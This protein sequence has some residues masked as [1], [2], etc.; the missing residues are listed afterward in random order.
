[1][2]DQKN[3]RV[4]IVIKSD[5][6]RALPGD[7]EPRTRTGPR[8]SLGLE[9]E[10]LPGHAGLE[11]QPSIPMHSGKFPMRPSYIYTRAERRV[12]PLYHWYP[13]WDEQFSVP[14]S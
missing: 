9:A 11:H 6:L 3:R 14:R 10:L 1:L 8:P 5:V 4:E 13:D 7:P 12:R 2:F